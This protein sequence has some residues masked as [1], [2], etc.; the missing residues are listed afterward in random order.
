MGL[1]SR[2]TLARACLWLAC[3]GAV[4]LGSVLAIHWHVEQSA[5]PRLFASL[6]E[7]P[8]REV[9]LVLGTSRH[10]GTGLNEFYLG[11][12]EAAADL[13]HAERVERL[14]VSGSHPSKYYDEPVAMK[15][16]LV[17]RDVPAE[18]ITE[19]GGGLRTL[20]SVV[21]AHTLEG[22]EAFTIISQRSH[23]ARAVYIGINRGLD[24]VAYCAPD[25]PGPFEDLGGF[26]E[27]GARV[28]AFLD[29]TVLGTQPELL[30]RPVPQS[31]GMAEKREVD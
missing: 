21:R 8:T 19:D 16:D 17:A 12:I 24:V 15:R 5:A 27:Y 29:V 11:R 13:Y 22:L 1:S 7:V 25:I 9:G 28:K 30:D 14:I 2:E 20:D 4:A 6:E 10:R 3:L 31:F 26:R 18:S 23:A